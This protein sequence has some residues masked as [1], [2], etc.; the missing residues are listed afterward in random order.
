M[1]NTIE[2]LRDTAEAL[3]R[4]REAFQQYM[5]EEPN[6]RSTEEFIIAEIA[7]GEDNFGE[8]VWQEVFRHHTRGWVGSY[9]ALYHAGRTAR[10]TLVRRDFP[11]HDSG[12]IV[13]T[14]IKD[15]PDG[16][17]G[18]MATERR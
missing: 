2:A 13:K 1:Q 16:Y 9:L 7:I 5:A 4:E 10:L 17:D 11:N 6:D 8:T 15:V 3:L 12:V 14:L 18:I